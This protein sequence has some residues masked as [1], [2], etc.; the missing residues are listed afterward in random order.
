MP[1]DISVSIVED[2]KRTR[3]GLAALISGTPGYR[4]LG[5]F[6]S[7]EEA[8]I[9]LQIDP[10]DVVLMDIKL[11]G[12]SGIEGVHR[13]KAQNPSLQILMLTVYGD[14]D[15]VFEAICA[16]AS[17]YLLKDTPPMKLLDAIRELCRGGAPMSPEIA[18]KVVTMFQKVAPPRNEAHKLSPRELQVLKLLADG[19]SYKTA[20][21]ALPVSLDTMRFH[22]RNIYEK[23]HVHSKSEAVLKALRSGILS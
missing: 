7:M 3:E 17:G 1:A 2:Q 6:G 8:L 19:H 5:R 22:I 10:P 14:N 15:Y 13:L 18:R 16:G 12:M 11:P 23:L 9:K 21:D 20:A 4:T